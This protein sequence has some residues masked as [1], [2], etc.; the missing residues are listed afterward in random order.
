MRSSGWHPVSA[1]VKTARVAARRARA[2]L[3][4]VC[5]REIQVDGGLLRI[6]R[7]GVDQYESVD[8]PAAML[9][10]LR[11]S[12]I[13]ID[14]FTFMQKLP[15][16]SPKYDYPME[17]DN[18]AALRISTFDQ[19]WTKQ[20]NTNGRKALRIGERKGII[21]REVPFDDAL[22]RAISVLYNEC[23][24]RQGKPFPHYRKDL[25]T[26]RRES[27]MFLERSFFLGAF[28]EEQLVGFAKL[29]CDQDRKQAGLLQILSMIQHW[30]KAP[31]KA[32]IAHAVR[33]CAER[34]IEHL[35]YASFAYGKKQRDSLSDFKQRNGFRR[36]DLPRYYIPLT[37]VGRTALRLGMHRRLANRLPEPLLARLRTAR[38][39]WW[40]WRLQVAK[41]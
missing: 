10:A 41:R 2:L 21:V 26:V 1:R 24:I 35:L 18:V 22:V 38:R 28:F 3:V 8:D 12:G 30:D 34:K 39:Q 20:I 37:L 23:P 4:K 15:D 33:S 27:G 31:M 16:T 29:L 14:L 5:G 17:W 40:G 7:L 25:E 32:L 11:D 36:I 6:A 13:R 9:Q 19:W